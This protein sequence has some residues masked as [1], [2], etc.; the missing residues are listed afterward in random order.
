MV[1]KMPLNSLT[2]V[3]DDG[4]LVIFRVVIKDEEGS[5]KHD[6]IR[7]VYTV[8]PNVYC[9]TVRKFELEKLYS[10]GIH[11]NYAVL[12]D[13]L[14]ETKPVISH[15]IGMG[16]E[17]AVIV[18]W[19]MPITTK[20]DGIVEVVLP[21]IEGPSL[22]ASP[23]AEKKDPEPCRITQLEK[24]VS[25]MQTG[26]ILLVER[27]RSLEDKASPQGAKL[28]TF[29]ATDGMPPLVAVTSRTMPRP[30]TALGDT[31]PCDVFKQSIAEPG[32]EMRELV[33]R[34]L[35]D[36]PFFTINK[37]SYPL[38]VPPIDEIAHS[39]MQAVHDGRS[40]L[41]YV[42]AENAEEMRWRFANSVAINVAGGMRKLIA[43]A[44][45]ID[46]YR[47]GNSDWDYDFHRRLGGGMYEF[48][49]APQQNSIRAQYT[50]WR[51][52]LAK[53]SVM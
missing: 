15:R 5:D 28:F 29:E 4:T 48:L 30:R 39:R 8:G 18:R 25:E 47:T 2:L 24:T 16:I 17:R 21:L 31:N 1:S 52:D 32:T 45:E 22:S 51:M 41:G 6:G 10:G 9:D 53:R 19:T 26:M 7:F 36:D 37:L 43:I 42:L 40:F 34:R 11:Y 49:P 14:S 33:R 12:L 35:E 3:C 23:P 44:D 38:L 20:F 50:M 13:V 27:I 46:V